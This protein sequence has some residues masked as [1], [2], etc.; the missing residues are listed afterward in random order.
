MKLLYVCDKY[1]FVQYY[2]IQLVSGNQHNRS[3]FKNCSF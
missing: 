1:E 3:A 2:P